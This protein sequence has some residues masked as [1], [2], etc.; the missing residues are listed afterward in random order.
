VVRVAID[1]VTIDVLVQG[2]TTVISKVYVGDHDPPP[3]E[4]AFTTVIVWVPS[5]VGSI[6]QTDKVSDYAPPT[7]MK[8]LSGFVQV[9]TSVAV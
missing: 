8:V 3:Y 7:V 4:T 9:I 6:V 2:S 5:L 1:C